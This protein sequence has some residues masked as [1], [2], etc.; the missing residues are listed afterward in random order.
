MADS[1]VLKGIHLSAHCGVTKQERLQ[2]QP[3]LIDITFRCPNQKAFLSDSLT[4]TVDYASVIDHIRKV[5]QGEPFSLLE[6]LAEQISQRLFQ[7]FP[8]T[9]IK[10]WVRKTQPPVPNIKGS[11]G[12]HLNRTRSDY[13]NLD[14]SPPAPFLVSQLAYLPPGHVLDVATGT[15]RHALYLAQRGFSIHGIDRD[16]SA[17]ATLHDR[18]LNASLTSI[19]T[20]VL[21]LEH[22]P[23]AVPD[24]GTECYDGIIVFFY[25]FRPLFPRLFQA[26][27][28]GGF[29]L[30]ETFHIDNHH[31]RQHPRRPEYCLHPNELLSLLHNYRILHYEEGNHIGSDPRHQSF[32]VQLRAQKPDI[33]TSNTLQHRPVA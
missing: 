14:S 33:G 1:I 23:S 5:G 21:D 30:Y 20:E 19:T 18:A 17:L 13:L 7:E 22:D 25:L 28:P 15:G 8:M 24:L 2:P 26:L 31:Q 11:V 9:H 6:S 3:I 27:K 16:P 12:I 4:D 29:L 32:T 10:L